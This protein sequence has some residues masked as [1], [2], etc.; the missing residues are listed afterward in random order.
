[1]AARANSEGRANKEVLRAS[2]EADRAKKD[3]KGAGDK[4]KVNDEA[5]R[6]AQGPKQEEKARDKENRYIQQL[7]D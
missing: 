2:K 7:H 1:M 4:V 3:A 6:W 5:V